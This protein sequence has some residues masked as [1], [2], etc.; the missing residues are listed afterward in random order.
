MHALLNSAARVGKSEWCFISIH[1]YLWLIRIVVWQKPIQY[2]KA[3]LLQFKKEWGFR[4][5]LIKQIFDSTI[6][7]QSIQ[8]EH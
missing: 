1:V 4:L 7:Y 2:C 5:H 3:I 8:E 6:G